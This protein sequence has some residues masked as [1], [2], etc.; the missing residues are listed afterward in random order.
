MMIDRVSCYGWDRLPTVRYANDRCDR[1]DWLDR[2][3]PVLN[4]LKYE[5]TPEIKP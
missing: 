2:L 3:M 4:P 5:Y 1:L